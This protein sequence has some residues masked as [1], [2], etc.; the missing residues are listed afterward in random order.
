MSRTWEEPLVREKGANRAFQLVQKT[1]IPEFL[2]GI[3][4]TF[5]GLALPVWKFPVSLIALALLALLALQRQARLTIGGASWVPTMLTLALIYVATVSA[6]SHPTSIS[7]DWT[8]RAVRISFVMI[9]VMMLA[10]ERLHL[11]SLL[12]GLTFG[13]IANVF[14]FKLHLTSDDYQGALTGWVGDK[15]KAGMYYAVVGLLLLWQMRT[16]TARIVWSA[17]VMVPLWMTESRTS[18]T[19]YACGLIW[20]WVI[21]RRP[22]LI[23]WLAAGG[24]ILVVNF[25]ESNFAQVGQFAERSGSDILRLRIQAATDL[26]LASAPFWGMGLGEA[27][28]PIGSDNFFF[29]DSVATLRVEGGWPYFVVI[30]GVTL[31]VALRPLKSHK[32]AYQGMVTQ[33]GAITL[34]I[35]AWKLGEV[36]L[37]IPWAVLMGVAFNYVLKGEPESDT[38]GVL[39]YSPPDAQVMVRTGNMLMSTLPSPRRG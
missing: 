19:A 25:I 12:K 20:V 32:P 36:F 30:V 27:Y 13:L 21:S 35:C 17:L 37:T 38:E 31:I 34:L 5:D 22:V 7:S 15:N 10:T 2:L 18:M 11:G 28:V 26:K 4:L 3:M 33:G 14:A 23:R 39:D 6:M 29:H 8:R 9:F 24:V 16:R 1:R